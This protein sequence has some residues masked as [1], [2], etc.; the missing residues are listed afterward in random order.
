MDPWISKSQ[1]SLL[2][3][4]YLG[5]ENGVEGIKACSASGVS[6]VDGGAC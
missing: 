2:A 4:S 5:G 1:I 3:Y 6:G